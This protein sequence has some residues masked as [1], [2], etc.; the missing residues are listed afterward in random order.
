M[1]LISVNDVLN[2]KMIAF[3]IVNFEIIEEILFPVE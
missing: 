2:C 1:L 3:K